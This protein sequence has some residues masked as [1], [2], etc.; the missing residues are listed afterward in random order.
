M[1]NIL[2]DVQNI[3]GNHFDLK[4]D[5]FIFM[6]S[7]FFRIV[8]QITTQKVLDISITTRQHVIMKDFIIYYLYF[9]FNYFNI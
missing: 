3:D 8:N 9:C 7:I 2:C 5:K 4:N 1:H 6:F